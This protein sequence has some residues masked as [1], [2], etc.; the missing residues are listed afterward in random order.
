MDAGQASFFQNPHFGKL[1][2]EPK[3]DISAPKL[4][5]GIWTIIN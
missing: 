1:P 2:P 3:K 5:N 4:E